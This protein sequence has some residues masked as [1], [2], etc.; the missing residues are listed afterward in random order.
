MFK[1]TQ[2]HTN[3]WEVDKLFIQCIVFL[4]IDVAPFEYGQ[5]YDIL[6]NDKQYDIII[7]NFVIIGCSC[8]YFVKMLAGSKGDRGVY[9]C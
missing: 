8:V 4:T 9:V 1:I 3:N 6:S 7:G 5:I 2:Q